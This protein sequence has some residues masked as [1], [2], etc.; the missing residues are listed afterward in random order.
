MPIVNLTGNA[1]TLQGYQLTT[2]EEMLAA[3]KY[4]SAGGYVGTINLTR[5]SGVNVYEM[6]IAHPTAGS[7]NA[8]INDWMVIENAS[9]AKVVPAAS[10]ASLYTL[11]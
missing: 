11:A 1:V 2:V 3:L 10:F 5:P 4:I 9:V 7:Q 8:K 6:Y